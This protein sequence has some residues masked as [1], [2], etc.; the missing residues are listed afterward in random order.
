MVNIFFIE[1]LHVSGKG[2]T[3]DI[4]SVF[5]SLLIGAEVVM[6]LVVRL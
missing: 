4:K 2:R 1:W 6:Y 3:V 5:M